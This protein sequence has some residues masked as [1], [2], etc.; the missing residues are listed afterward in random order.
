MKTKRKKAKLA[1]TALHAI[2]NDLNAHSWNLTRPTMSRYPHGRRRSEMEMYVRN[3]P[4]GTLGLRIGCLHACFQVTHCSNQKPFEYSLNIPNATVPMSHTFSLSG[5]KPLVLPR[6]LKFDDCVH[7]CL[8]S[9]GLSTSNRGSRRHLR[10][11][12]A[13]HRLF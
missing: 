11:G 7:A 8:L 12:R 6:S 2:F 10:P 9:G 3:D 13:G 4:N 5:E 1:G